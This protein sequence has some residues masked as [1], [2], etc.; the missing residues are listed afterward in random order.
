MHCVGTI[1]SYIIYS[2]DLFFNYRNILTLLP[3]PLPSP[4]FC[5]SVLACVCV[6]VRCTFRKKTNHNFSLPEI[7]KGKRKGTRTIFYNNFANTYHDLFFWYATFFFFVGVYIHCYALCWVKRST[8]VS[9]QQMIL[10]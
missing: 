4:L 7:K 1:Q 2:N 10:R 9:E 8:Y 3:P 5:I 6:C